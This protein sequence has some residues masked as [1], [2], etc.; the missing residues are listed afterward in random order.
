MKGGPRQRAHRARGTGHGLRC[1]L[2]AGLMCLL[3]PRAACPA[4][5]DPT[6]AAALAGAASAT[7][8]EP[9][10]D[11]LP[12]KLSLPTIADA[13]A[14]QTPGFRLQLGY[15]YGLARGLSGA[16]DMD[17]HIIIM[18]AGARLDRDWS[19]LASFQYAVAGGQVLGMRYS[20]TL[21]PT[22][23]FH[24]GFEL[25]V[26]AGFAGIVDGGSGRPEPDAAQRDGLVA[27]YTLPDNT[28][29]LPSCSGVGTLA[30][31][32]VGWTGVIGPLAATTFSLQADGQWT[33]CT[34]ELGR[35]E[36][37]TARPIVRRQWWAHQGLALT[38]TVA[39]R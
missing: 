23:H 37:D 15:G 39:W 16:P 29:L 7:E 14:W 4:P 36:P 2:L 24:G 9:E 3:A 31:A 17:L 12:F 6:A 32:R 19:L 13:M 5:S 28:R 34:E 8:A 35:V 11:L 25:A 1:A 30:L 27:S 10:E 20:G 26:G 18:R 38:W 33:G 21:D 22:W